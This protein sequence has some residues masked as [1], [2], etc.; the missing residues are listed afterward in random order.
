MSH[1]NWPTWL[2]NVNYPAPGV[3]DLTDLKPYLEVGN[4]GRW[5]AFVDTGWYYKDTFEQ[6]AY[7]LPGQLSTT[8]PTGES[9]HTESISFRP[10]WGPVLVYTNTGS[11]NP[12]TEAT[13]Y[14]QHAN[15][16]AP[17]VTGVWS[18]AGSG[19]YMTT[20][21]TGCL[22]LGVR[23]LSNLTLGSVAGTGLLVNKKQYYFDRV[24]RELYVK[25]VDSLPINLFLDLLYQKPQL[26]IREIVL[27]EDD[28]VRPSYTNIEDVQII[29]GYDVETLSAHSTGY[30]SHTLPDT[31][32]SDWVVLDYYIKN[33]YILE[34]H[35][36]I[37]LYTSQAS[38]EDITIYYETSLPDIIRPLQLTEPSTASL[39][40][41]PLY[42]DAYRAGY[43]SIYSSTNNASALWTVDKVL[44]EVD[45]RF[46]NADVGEMFCATA[47]VTD[48]NGLP[49]PHYPVTI[50]LSTDASAISI[51]PNNNMTDGRGEIH[52]LVKPSTGYPEYVVQVVAATVTGSASGTVIT[53][54]TMLPSSVFFGGE[55]HLIVTNELT[56]RRYRRVFC[57]NTLL[58]GIPKTTSTITIK[59][60]EASAVEFNGA[61]A[62]SKI[63]STSPQSN[64]NLDAVLGLDPSAIGYMPQ[65][66]DRISAY[67]PLLMS[68]SKLVRPEEE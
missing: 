1:K 57:K 33:S 60:E 50:S 49:I 37:K 16:L 4:N 62:N 42:A 29:R 63:T 10:S 39:N 36:T 40:V 32:L 65:E 45:K 43:L 5:L 18:S 2:E 22:L 7:V 61:V 19:M 66:N 31:Y 28:G 67:T 6:Y 47:W 21:P 46:V 27:H 13:Y 54:S 8:A 23:D 12:P 38:G 51:M 59:T 20:V 14:L 9:T 48:S 56:P 30:I 41:N 25:P 64:L 58:D 34:D 3:G 68:Q 17:A 24:T 11:A 35:Q 53:T 52:F 26:R 15:H 55:T 44:V